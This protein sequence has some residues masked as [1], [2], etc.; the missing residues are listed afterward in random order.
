MKSC[1]LWTLHDEGG[2]IS[3][4]MFKMNKV[5]HKEIKGVI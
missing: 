5:K 4:A 2:T 3:N 1:N